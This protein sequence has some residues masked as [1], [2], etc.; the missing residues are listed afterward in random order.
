MPSRRFR[1][2]TPLDLPRTLGPLRHGARDA[3]V[4]LGPRGMVRASRTPDG[5]VTLRLDL[6]ADEIEAEAWGPGADW[7]LEQAP[8]LV[9]VDDDVSDFDPARHPAVARAARA[10][11]G[12]RIGASGRIDDLLVPTI[13]GQKVTAAEAFRAWWAMIRAWGSDAPGPYDLR[14]PPSP[15]EIASHPYEDFHPFSI[16]RKRA[17][18]IRRAC[19]RFSRLQEAVDLPREDA[20]RRLTVLPGLGPWT[21]G[22]LMRT[23]MG[24]PDAVEIGD[25]HIPN[26]ICW[27]LAGEPRGDDA[28]MLE[29]LEPFAGHRG[30]VVRLVTSALGKAPAYGPKVRV[31]DIRRYDPPRRRW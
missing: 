8:R 13:L 7:A 4:R 24:D 6:R 16:E 29:L 3:T 11:P 25:F 17:D 28:R 31:G 21:A 20:Y 9:G 22:I 14:L 26:A 30:R 19:S 27:N 12:L 10:R 5:P 18:I 1:V 23:A 15:A 2:P